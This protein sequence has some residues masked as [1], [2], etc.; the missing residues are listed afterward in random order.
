MAP[1]VIHWWFDTKCTGVADTYY[2]F[3]FE[4]GAPDWA[5]G[6]GNNGSFTHMNTFAFDFGAAEG[7]KILAPR[8]GQVVALRSTSTGSC[9]CEPPACNPG[10]CKNCT[11]PNDGNFLAILHED[12]TLGRFFHFLPDDG[13]EV[14]EGQRVKRGELLGTVGST[15]CSTA[16][17]LHFEV[18]EAPGEPSIEITFEADVPGSETCYLPDTG[19]PVESTNVENP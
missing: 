18:G 5:L 9:Y 2:R 13:V 19:D 17:H 6:Q 14:I 1:S 8:A 12:G 16:P 3:P 4:G 11:A 7:T 10:V 15:G